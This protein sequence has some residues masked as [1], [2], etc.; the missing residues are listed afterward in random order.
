MQWMWKGN[1]DFA[2]RLLLSLS[3]LVIVFGVLPTGIS[4]QSATALTGKPTIAQVPSPL[5]IEVRPAFDLPLGDSAQGFFYGG[6]M[7]LGFALG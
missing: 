7:G 3:V 5:S 1:R 4:A 6:S 2:R